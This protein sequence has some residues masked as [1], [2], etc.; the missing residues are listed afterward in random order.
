MIDLVIVGGGAAGIGAGLEAR[1]RS[2]DFLI[3]EASDRLGGRARTIEWRGHKLDL[4]CGWLHSAERNSWRVEA[5]ARSFAIDRH[6]ASWF[7]QF[8]DLGFA[9]EDQQEARTAFESLQDRLGKNPPA[10]DRASE[11]LLP[12]CEWNDWL[13]AISG[14]VNGVPLDRVSVADFLNY[15]DE[16]SPSNWRLSGGYGAL[17]ESIGRTLPHRL[18]TPA[19]A[20][21][22]RADGID[23]H[24]ADGMIAARKAIVSVPP[25]QL[26]RIRF[27]PP[28][29]ALDAADDLPMGLADKLFLSLDRAEEFP[30]EAHLIG[31]PHNAE[32]GSY[33][34]NP[35]GT[36]VIECFFGG[37]GAEA[38]EGANLAEAAEV[39]IGEL[40]GLLGSGIRRRLAP[41]AASRWRAEPW[42]GGS[43][44]Y[45]RP[46]KVDARKHLRDAGD[47][48]LAFAGEALS[49]FDYATAHGAHDTGREAVER[50]YGGA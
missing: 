13:N 11:G 8:R 17:I 22:R 35:L 20:I 12:D 40:A 36:P 23:V 6:P 28:I 9:P 29:D 2:I 46:G 27:D 26:D 38:I 45:A 31:D 37:L 15:L 49:I 41:I 25:G 30:H 3:V 19:R 32:T 47:E 18:A 48:N 44:S 5:E 16:A 50:L 34:I 1:R 7:D 42:I 21:G 10:S 4:G 43:Y 39:A 14:Y 33:M 24:T